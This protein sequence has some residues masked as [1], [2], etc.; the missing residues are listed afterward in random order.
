MVK[1]YR[2]ML[3]TGVQYQ[4][5]QID[6]AR[7]PNASMEPKVDRFEFDGKINESVMWGNSSASP[8]QRHMGL[9]SDEESPETRLLRLY[10]ALEMP[11]EAADYHFALLGTCQVFWA[12][13]RERPRFLED[14]ERLC[15]MDIQL[16]ERTWQ[17]DPETDFRYLGQPAFKYLLDLYEGEG[18]FEDAI[19]VAERAASFLRSRP[20]D[21]SE[22]DAATGFRESIKELRQRMVEGKT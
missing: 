5:P 7:L 4:G 16:I 22:A 1:W 19:A 11:G 21:G 17:D 18:Y 9:A 14:L 20:N 13:R 10:E 6:R 8:V 2:R 3:E 12:A 15:W